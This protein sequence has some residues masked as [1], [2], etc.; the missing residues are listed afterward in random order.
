LK[1]IEYKIGGSV[2]ADDAPSQNSFS[3]STDIKIKGQEERR[4]IPLKLRLKVLQRDNFRC[5]LCGKSPATNPGT[6]LHIDHIVPFSKGGQT[7]AE[8]LRTLCA[9][10]NWG[11]GNDKN[12]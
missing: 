3:E 1:F 11:K 9:E 4:E 12:F 5:V 7:T 8:N 6:V 10:C 2:L